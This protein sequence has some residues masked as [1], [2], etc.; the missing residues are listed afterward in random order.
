MKTGVYSKFNTYELSYQICILFS[1]TT[2]L[3]N[4]VFDNIKY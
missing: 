4:H 1:K 3:R 2:I